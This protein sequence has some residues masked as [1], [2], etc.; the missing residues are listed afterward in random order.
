MQAHLLLVEDDPTTRLSFVYRL[1]YAGYEVTQAPDGETALTLLEENA[2]DVVITDIMLGGVDGMEVLHAARLQSYRPEVIVL[3]GHGSLDTA[4]QAVREDAFDYLVKPCSLEQLLGCVAKAVD[5]HRSEQQVRAAAQTL[6][7][8]LYGEQ[9][10]RFIPHLPALPGPLPDRS[11]STP[12]STTQI[13]IGAL[14]VGVTRKQVTF[15]GQPVQLTPTE[16][17]ILR[18]LAEHAGHICFYHDIVRSTHRIVADDIDVQALLKPH[19]S[20]LRKKLSPEY[21]I[22]ERGSGYR[23]VNPDQG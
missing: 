17:A 8:V 6:L 14:V 18:Y 9:E 12:P 5:R 3:T 2:F 13:T 22:T 21:L 20:N 4:V 15:A 7:T 23:L 11:S 10:P 1:Q 19:I 16:Y